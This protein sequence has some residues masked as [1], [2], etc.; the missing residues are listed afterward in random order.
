ML[1]GSSPFSNSQQHLLH[2]LQVLLDGTNE[3]NPSTDD[4]LDSIVEV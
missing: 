3:V 2:R 1:N 4:M